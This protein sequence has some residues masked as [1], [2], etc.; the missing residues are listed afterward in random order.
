MRIFL[1]H[2]S[3]DSAVAIALKQWLAEQAPALDRE[4]FL[5][6]DPT[7]GIA[8]GRQWKAELR[9]AVTR[10]EAVLCLVSAHW[11]NSRECQV[12]YRTAEMLGKR[13]FVARL[14]PVG[15]G[16]ITREW[17]RSDLYGSGP[18]TKIRLPGR[19]E[20]VVLRTAGLTRLLDGLQQAGIAAIHFPWPPPNNLDRSPY[21]GWRPL[22][23]VDA[24]VYF[25]RDTELLHALDR[26]RGIRVTGSRRLFVVLGPSGTGKSSFLRAGLIPRLAREDHEFTMLDIVRPERFAITGSLGLAATVHATRAGLGLPLPALGDIKKVL[27]RGDADVLREWLAEIH[28]VASRRLPDSNSAAPTLLLPVDQAEELFAADAGPEGR[29]LLDLLSAVLTA[30][31]GERVPLIVAATIRTDRYEVLQ[32]APQLAGIGTELFDELTPMPRHRFRDII[33]GPAARASAAGHRVEFTDELIDRLLSDCHDGADTLPLLALTLAT[34]HRDYGHTGRLTLEHY[35]GIGGVADVVSTEI[36]KI[37][38]PDTAT[39]EQQ[40]D[41]LR[42]AF[43]PWL[44]TVAPDTDQP[45]RR[46]ARYDDL[47]AAARPLIDRFVDRRLLVKGHD[48]RSVTVEVALES[49]LRRWDDL[50]A[51]LREQADDLRTADTLENAAADWERHHRAD[52]WLLTGTRLSGAQALAGRPGYRDRLAGVTEYL[53]ASRRHENQRTASKLA[54]A[55]EHAEALR[56]RARALVVLMVVTALAAVLAGT[57]FLLQA[58]AGRRA[59]ARA[60]EAIATR[61]ISEGTPMLVGDRPGGTVRGVRQILAADALGSSPAT[62]HAL[63]NAQYRLRDIIELGPDLPQPGRLGSRIHDP[64]VVIPENGGNVRIVRAGAPE[65]FSF[66]PGDITVRSVSEDGSTVVIGDKIGNVRVIRTGAPERSFHMPNQVAEAEASADGS[67]VVVG[68]AMGNVRIVRADDSGHS[69]LLPANITG[70][71]VSADGSTAVVGD[72]KGNVRIVRA[73]GA[74]QT[75]LL[76]GWITGVGVS[77]DGSTAVVGDFKG[78]VRIVRADGAEQ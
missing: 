36:D 23:P 70:V 12:E 41:L 49:L 64:A 37:L 16:D 8:A 26:L 54:R 53:T 61:L 19:L 31:I 2:S 39:R 65:Q 20:P 45:L 60:R 35:R 15:E 30:T 29:Q 77:A 25:G 50:A 9:A 68:D 33:T 3:K 71:G 11:L 78:N 10:C 14:G 48:G 73:D 32:S 76:D 72:F 63:L 59:D 22:D 13:I 38:N 43:V 75:F 7:T 58:E 47:P 66:L 34:L 55:R 5:D 69:S 40:L 46:I 17:Q 21:R 6:V 24:A 62:Q 52:A 1:S 57:G 44:A 4:V 51:W 42:T 74:E 67:T 56:R 18:S 28:V 27:L